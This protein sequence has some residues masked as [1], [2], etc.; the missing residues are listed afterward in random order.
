MRHPRKMSSSD[1]E[2]YNRSKN[3]VICSVSKEVALFLCCIS[4]ICQIQVLQWI[5]ISIAILFAVFSIARDIL[6]T[7]GKVK[8][9]RGKFPWILFPI[10][11]I[12]ISLLFLAKTKAYLIIILVLIIHVVALILALIME[13]K[14]NTH[15]K[16]E[17]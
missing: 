17:L 6:L 4:F 9:V 10:Q 5:C 7:F 15:K 8:T 3:D 16:N 2:L 12:V 11:G 14:C 13:H 1:F